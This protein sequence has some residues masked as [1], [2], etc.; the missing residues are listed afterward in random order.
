LTNT[1]P[2]VL[3]SYQAICHTIDLV[4]DHMVFQE[5]GSHHLRIH[6]NGVEVKSFLGKHSKDKLVYEVYFRV[7]NNR[8]SRVIFWANTSHMI[9]VVS[10]E[11]YEVTPLENIWQLDDGF[12]ALDPIFALSLKKPAKL[13]LFLQTWK[14][15]KFGKKIMMKTLE[16]EKMTQKVFD[17]DVLIPDCKMS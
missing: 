15:S 16:I 6:K 10:L 5:Q 14:D 2:N 4:S 1:F 13:V 9:S 12:Q 17:F 8:D 7:T 11:T 3:V